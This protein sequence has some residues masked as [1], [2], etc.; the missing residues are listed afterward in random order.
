MTAPHDR[1]RGLRE[2]QE[3]LAGCVLEAAQLEIAAAHDVLHIPP[4]G[5]LTRRLHA[6]AD[7]YP[8]RI[9]EALVES[10]PAVTH[11]I[12]EQQTTELTRRYV[13]AFPPRSFNLNHAGSALVD[14]LRTDLTAESFPFLPDLAMLEWRVL[15]AFHAQELP[16]LDPAALAGWDDDAWQS[17]WLRF[18]PAVAVVSSP[19][20]LRDLHAARE[21][22]LADIDIDLRVGPDH[23]LVRRHGLLVHTDAVDAVEARALQGLLGGTTLG[24]VMEQLADTDHD[25]AAVSAWF[26][27][28][29]QLG[30]IVHVERSR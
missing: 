15:R 29:M 11:L 10:F 8:A 27:R 4:G 25:P 21:T 22:P 20:P 9:R 18:Q 7:G 2:T 3:W 28:W 16:P 1:P 26:G 6:Y 13:A 5:D 12:G 23:V 17:A 14:F 24:N 19:W 30:M